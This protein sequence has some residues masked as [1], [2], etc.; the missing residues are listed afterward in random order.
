MLRPALLTMALFIMAFTGVGCDSNDAA[1]T[2]SATSTT[3]NARPK[4]GILLYSGQ[5]PYI[6]GV[7]AA[8]MQQLEGRADVHLLEAGENELI[9]EDQLGKLLQEGVQGLAIN[10]VNPQRAS[11]FMSAIR[12]ADIPAIFFNREPELAVIEQGNAR[13]VGTSIDEAGVMQGDLIKQIWTE[14]P[15]YDRNKDGILQYILLQGNA[16]NPEALGRT[17]YSGR[18]ACELGVKMQQLGVNYVCNWDEALARESM[19]GAL[20]E[21]GSAV[22]LI[23]S[24]NDA[25]ALGALH[26]LQERGF[27]TGDPEKFIPLIGVDAIPA[28]TE[29]IQKGLMS[30]TVKQ[31]AQGMAK[32]VAAMLLNA[33]QNKPFLNGTPYTWDASGMAVRIPYGVF[34]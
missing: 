29:A 5:D 25:M 2:S 14:N 9:Q 11:V 13:Y 28:A 19:R 4:I 18:R 27:N 23:L 8:L 33:V 30:G 1:E 22:E 10:L 31:D 7:G 32:A 20:G 15:Q 6:S 21:Y 12:K 3:S 16:D 17:E 34:R 26:A 24:N